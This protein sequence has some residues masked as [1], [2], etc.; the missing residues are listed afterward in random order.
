VSNLFEGQVALANIQPLSTTDV[1]R[2][3]FCRGGVVLGVAL[4]FFRASPL[5]SPALSRASS[6]LGKAASAE[7][8]DTAQ[9]D[10][11]MVKYLSCGRNI[12]QQETQFQKGQE[13]RRCYAHIYPS[14]LKSNGRLG[15][16]CD[17]RIN[18]RESAQ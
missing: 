1:L 12:V 3:R 7:G 13:L 9:T 15:R 4:K 5:Q 16:Y 10:V 18:R 8:P 14:T 2:K 17:R 6:L 11:G